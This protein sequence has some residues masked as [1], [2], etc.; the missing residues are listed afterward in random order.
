MPMRRIKIR[1]QKTFARMIRILM[2]TALVES[3][4]EI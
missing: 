3:P 1:N 2:P 4:D